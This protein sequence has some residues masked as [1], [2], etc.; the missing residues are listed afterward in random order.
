VGTQVIYIKPSSLRETYS[1]DDCRLLDELD[2]IMA[3]L[4]QQAAK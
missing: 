1:L 3:D 2:Q 4:A